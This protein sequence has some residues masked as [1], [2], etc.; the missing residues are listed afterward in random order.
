[1]VSTILIVDDSIAV[2]R[3]LNRVLTQSGYQVV[4]CRD[5]KEALEELNQSGRSFDL[6]ISDIEMPRLDG[7]ALIREIRAHTR[8]HSLAIMMLTSRENDL[9]RQKAMSL[10]ATSYL[11]KPFHPAELLKGMSTLLGKAKKT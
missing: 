5:G 1:D 4:E 11:T 10:G 8:W 6:V 7:F 2:R 9:H 3:L